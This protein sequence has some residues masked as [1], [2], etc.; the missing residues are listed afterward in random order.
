MSVQIIEKNGR[1]KW[2]VIPYDEYCR[3]LEA[4]E[5]R[6]DAATIEDAVRRLATGEDERLPADMIER[7]LVEN[8]YRVWREHRRMT[9]EAVA[10]AAGLTKAYLSMIEAG[11]RQPSADARERIAAALD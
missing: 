4:L 3:L 8:P 9:L 10:D 5:D 2:A 11:K 1:P 7:L 6:I